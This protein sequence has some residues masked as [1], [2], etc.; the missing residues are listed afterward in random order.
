VVRSE[1]EDIV[2]L[3]IVYNQPVKRAILA[4]IGGFVIPFVYTV[5]IGPL[6][7]R[8]HSDALNQLLG[9]PVRWPIITTK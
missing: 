4:I 7:L 2:K 9:Y 5:I 6:T 3:L 1:I 8:I